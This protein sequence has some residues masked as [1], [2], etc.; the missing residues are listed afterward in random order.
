MIRHKKTIG[1]SRNDGRTLLSLF[2]YRSYTNRIYLEQKL[3]A[4]KEHDFLYPQ[5]PINTCVLGGL[6]TSSLIKI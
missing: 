5:F 1:L 6:V 2:F 4:E 3:T